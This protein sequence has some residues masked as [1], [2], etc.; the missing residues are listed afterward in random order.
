[1]HETGQAIFTETSAY[2]LA[3]VAAIGVVAYIGS[4][5]L[6]SKNASWQDRVTFIWLVSTRSCNALLNYDNVINCVVC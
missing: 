4:K 5:L 2:S 1:M 3:A 6:L